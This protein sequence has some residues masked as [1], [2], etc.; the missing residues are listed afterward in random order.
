MRTRMKEEAKAKTEEKAS[1]VW[2]FS[3]GTV[4]HGANSVQACRRKMFNTTRAGNSITYWANQISDGI[5]EIQFTPE[6]FPDVT[7]LVSA[8]NGN[9]AAKIARCSLASD[10][11]CPIVMSV[12][13]TRK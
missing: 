13:Y 7:V 3:N 6:V 9:E 2:Y 1:C 12:S 8:C 5:Y 11:G 10:Y 4:V